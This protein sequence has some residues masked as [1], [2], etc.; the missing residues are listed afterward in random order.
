MAILDDDAF[1][2]EAPP[3]V[4]ETVAADTPPIVDETPEV[5]VDTPTPVTEEV[6]E[7]PASGSEAETPALLALA[8]TSSR[9]LPIATNLAASL[10]AFLFTDSCAETALFQD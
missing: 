10:A 6:V 9:S 2:N 8:I 4:T 3:V 7:V 1:L 5:V